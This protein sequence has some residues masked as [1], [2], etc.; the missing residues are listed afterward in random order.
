MLV[1]AG[2][3]NWNDKVIDYLPEF[4]TYDTFV[5]SNYTIMDLLCHRSGLG[6]GAGDLMWFPDGNDYTMK[7]ILGNFQYQTPTSS[8]RTKYDYTL[9]N[10]SINT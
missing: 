8:F 4:K 5:T 2:K 7:E 6:L 3:L 9:Y 1:D 10:I